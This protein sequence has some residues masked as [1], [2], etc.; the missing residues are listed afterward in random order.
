MQT[1]SNTSRLRSVPIKR[2]KL[3]VLIVKGALF[4]IISPV[5]LA[6]GFVQDG[7]QSEVRR[8]G[9]WMPYGLENGCQE[10][11]SCSVA[12]MMDVR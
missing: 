4:R 3:R 2:E 9:Y 11:R 10:V 7:Y 1:G 5:F 6:L 12:W 8:S